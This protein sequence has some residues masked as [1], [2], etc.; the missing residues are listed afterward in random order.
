[1]KL[2]SFNCRG[3]ASPKKKLAMK[4]LFLS[5]LVDVILLQETLSKVKSIIPLLNSRLSGWTFH[6]LDV[7]GHSGG[8]AV[9]FKNRSIVLKNIW[10]GR[11]FLGSDIYS[12]DVE[13]EMRII[14]VYGPCHNKESFW[15]RLLRSS[16]LQADN[17]ILGEHMNFSL[18]YMESWGQMA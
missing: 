4:R 10:G 13:D 16:L 11:G 5:K 8:V 3:L 15:R 17:V 14:N 1:M 9:G 18:G 12:K 6:A 2:L 7:S